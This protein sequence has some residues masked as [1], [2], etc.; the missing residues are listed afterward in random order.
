MFKHKIF[1]VVLVMFLAAVTLYLV[2]DDSSSTESGFDVHNGTGVYCDFN[3]VYIE[4]NYS[5]GNVDSSGDSYGCVSK[6]WLY[7][8]L[9]NQ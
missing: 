3:Q 9:D 8:S 5:T 7:G 6:K 1:A 2:V 4:T